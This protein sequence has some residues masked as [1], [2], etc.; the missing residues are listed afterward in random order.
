MLLEQYDF[1]LICVAIC[2]VLVPVLA[3]I[4]WFRLKS[5]REAERR[6]YAEARATRTAELRSR[7]GKAAA[8]R[9]KPAI[10]VDPYRSSPSSA[11]AVNS[12]SSHNSRTATDD[13]PYVAPAVYNSD[14][15]RGSCDL[16]SSSYSGSSSS[17]NDCSSSD[18]S[19]S[20]SSSD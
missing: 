15:S 11:K 10:A 9:F 2:L 14:Y 20:S 5:K 18:S 1:V 17:S 4:V 12:S 6:G 8:S 13:Y 16:S 3:F 7:A 19:S